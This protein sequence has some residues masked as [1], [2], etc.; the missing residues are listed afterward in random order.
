MNYYTKCNNNFLYFGIG[1]NSDEEI[2]EKS[3]IFNNEYL[4]ADPLVESQDGD[5]TKIVQTFSDNIQNIKTSL[6]NIPEI[7]R[8]NLYPSMPIKEE[9]ISSPSILIQK[10]TTLDNTQNNK[11]IYNNR[12]FGDWLYHKKNE[13]NHIIKNKFINENPNIIDNSLFFSDNV[14]KFLKM[15]I[16]S[17]KDF[18]FQYSKESINNKITNP[19]I[20]KLIDIDY[21]TCIKK[22]S[23]TF[24][25]NMMNERLEN[26]FIK[27]QKN[28]FGISENNNL[29]VIEYIKNNIND[30]KEAYNIINLSFLEMVKKFE[31]D[32]EN[33]LEALLIQMET[34]MRK[35]LKAKQITLLY[36]LLIEQR[37]EAFK[38]IL[39]LL[40]Y[41]FKQ[42]FQLMDGRGEKENEAKY[43]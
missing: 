7:N 6:P 30:E 41:K 26:F 2:L 25:E 11:I 9:G 42:Y 15:K 4:Y 20:F 23:K 8:R 38:N 1:F 19:S 39:K 32:K 12:T 13:L 10:N 27:Y 3:A 43:D 28:N 5:Y 24:N 16:I 22:T 14:P 29:N 21:D 35:L 33:G 17:I 31:N 40:C 18:I 37:I 36:N 34:S